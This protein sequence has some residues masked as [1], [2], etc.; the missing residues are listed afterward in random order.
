MAVEMQGHIWNV[1]TDSM[2]KMMFQ[3]NICK[4]QIS[5]ANENQDSI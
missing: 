1:F 3:I 5:E 2:D 4:K